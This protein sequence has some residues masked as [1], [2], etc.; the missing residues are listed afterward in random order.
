MIS[1]FS[2][3]KNGLKKSSDKLSSGISDIFT[4][5][6]IDSET[7]DEL[8]ELLITSDMGY[9]ASSEV[10]KQFSKQKLNKEASDIEITTGI[11]EH[12]IRIKF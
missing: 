8:E 9:N 5:R 1:F 11:G 6:K 10:I 4:K 12:T 3:I 7:L 2:K